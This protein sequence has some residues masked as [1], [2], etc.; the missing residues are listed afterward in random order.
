[1]TNEI[2]S[3]DHVDPVANH[4][5]ATHPAKRRIRF[6]LR[7][8]LLFTTVIAV[9]FGYRANVAREERPALD[10][11]R[12]S[13][14]SALYSHHIHGN[15]QSLIPTSIRESVGE[16]YFG[17][18]VRLNFRGGMPR[19]DEAFTL[20]GR[21]PAVTVLNT[22]ESGSGITDEGL[23][24]VSNLHRLSCFRLPDAQISDDGLR[25]LSDLTE[26]ELLDLGGN[27]ITDAGIPSFLNLKKLDILILART[28]VTDAG[29]QQFAAL[30]GLRYLNVQYTA[31]TK[32]GAEQL[33]AK[34][35]DCQISH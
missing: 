5:G 17:R 30:Q 26:M 22:D 19:S 32:A 14:G 6:S 12:Q 4:S 16:E 9:W 8:V 15:L 34:L 25:H 20:L 33:Q 24:H 11:V 29:I 10:L 3:S 7:A 13:G 2:V 31:V 35:P 18:A 1:M 23:R 21:L 28:S 27:K